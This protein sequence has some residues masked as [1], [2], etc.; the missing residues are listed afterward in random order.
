MQYVF[1]FFMPFLKSYYKNQED[2]C[3]GPSAES[4]NVCEE[5]NGSVQKNF[6]FS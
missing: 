2:F 4:D 5:K 6:E 1:S 3:L